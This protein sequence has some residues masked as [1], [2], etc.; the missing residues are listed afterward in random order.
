MLGNARPVSHALL[1]QVGRLSQG[2]SIQSPS[3]S[4]NRRV[5]VVG[6]KRCRQQEDS[7]AVTVEAKRAFADVN[8]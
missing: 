8:E 3:S 2:K 5:G 1:N 7:A 4:R 6:G